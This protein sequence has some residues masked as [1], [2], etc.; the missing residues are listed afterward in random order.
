[1]HPKLG[2]AALYPANAKGSHTTRNR[3]KSTMPATSKIS[4]KPNEIPKRLN[5]DPLARLALLRRLNRPSCCSLLRR[6]NWLS[7]CITDSLSGAEKTTTIGIGCS[8][9]SATLHTWLRQPPRR[10]VRSR[11]RQ[12]SGSDACGDRLSRRVKFHSRLHSVHLRLRCL[13]S[14]SA[15][16]PLCG[17]HIHPIARAG[18]W[19]YGH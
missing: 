8:A 1:M 13:C 2:A 18:P 17:N 4:T 12:A 16:S 3:R 14:K 9:K 5:S 15:T 10:P 6:W 11:H 19:S 7:C